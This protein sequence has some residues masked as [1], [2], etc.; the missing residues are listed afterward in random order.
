MSFDSADTG[1]SFEPDPFGPLDGMHHGA[2]RATSCAV[3]FVPLVANAEIL[4]IDDVM[5]R[6]AAAWVAL[7]RHPLIVDA[8]STSPM[9]PTASALDLGP[10]VQA[11]SRDVSY[12]PAGGLPRRYVDTHG[13]AARLLHEIQRSVPHADTIVVHA[14]ATDLARIFKHRQAQPLL[15]A[16][17]EPQSLKQAYAG[18]KWLSMRCGWMQARLIVVQASSERAEQI[19]RTLA[20]CAE[21]FMDASLIDWAMLATAD[22]A[23]PAMDWGLVELAAAQLGVAGAASQHRPRSRSAVQT[24]TGTGPSWNA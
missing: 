14:D 5:N 12:L 15:L 13:S 4:G 3:R 11:R 17:D 10:C 9:A 20:A 22:A 16:V 19:A 1:F 7:G 8:A 21:Q 2:C 18:W 6:L 23:S 24:S